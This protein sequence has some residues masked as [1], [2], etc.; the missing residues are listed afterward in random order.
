MA[1]PFDVS[2]GC[3]GALGKTGEEVRKRRETR[4]WSVKVFWAAQGR[5]VLLVVERV[6]GLLSERGK[7]FGGEPDDVTFLPPASREARFAVGLVAWRRV[8]LLLGLLII[9]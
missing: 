3:G 5:G 4:D 7:C 6:A 2:Q 9:E 1:A 8:R